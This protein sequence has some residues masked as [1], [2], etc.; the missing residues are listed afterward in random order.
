[1]QDFCSWKKKWGIS[2][3]NCINY[4]NNNYNNT[5]GINLFQLFFWSEFCSQYGMNSAHILVFDVHLL[6]WS[7]L[8]KVERDYKHT[9]WPICIWTILWG[10]L[11]VTGWLKIKNFNSSKKFMQI[12]L[13]VNKVYFFDIKHGLT[14]TFWIFFSKSK[15]YAIPMYGLQYP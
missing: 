12:P 7:E 8:R 5:G 15:N 13:K 14:M 2:K 4:N 1:M 6:L 10:C 3:Y 11:E 9:G